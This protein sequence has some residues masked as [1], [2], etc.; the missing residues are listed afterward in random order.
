MRDTG[1]ES[2]SYADKQRNS[3]FTA[4]PGYSTEFLNDSK[5]VYINHSLDGLE[6]I[7]EAA[8]RW[9]G[10]ILMNGHGGSGIA[11]LAKS[12]PNIWANFCAM[13]GYGSIAQLVE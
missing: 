7:S 12:I 10:V 5:L 8:E 1:T 6:T 4:L 9:P 11:G 3:I 2:I 13:I